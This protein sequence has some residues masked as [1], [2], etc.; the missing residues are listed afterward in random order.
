MSWKATDHVAGLKGLSIAEKGVALLLANRYNDDQ[1]YAWPSVLRL[2]EEA[3]LSER[4]VRYILRRLED[5]GAIATEKNRGRGHTNKY[6]FP[7]LKGAQPA[8]F[9]A[10]EKGHGATEKGHP[11]APGTVIEPSYD[12]DLGAASP[13]R[14]GSL[15]GKR[16]RSGPKGTPAP[17]GLE[18]QAEVVRQLTA[19][20]VDEGP[21]IALVCKYGVAHVQ[22][23]LPRLITYVNADPLKI[24][25]LP[26]FIV[27]GLKKGWHPARSRADIEFERVYGRPF[28]HYLADIDRQG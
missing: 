21:A 26:A 18:V 10:T 8:P 5:K 24:R 16:P 2:A 3:G 13:R 20:G 17:T 7:G 1:G 9:T 11:V 23:V 19:H 15:P 14:N 6:I 22:K 4:G 27:E 28:K 25:S 12:D